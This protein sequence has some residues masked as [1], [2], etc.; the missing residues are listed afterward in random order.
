MGKADRVL[1]GGRVKGGKRGSVLGE[2]KGRIMGGERVKGG[3][4]GRV[5]GEEKGEGYRWEMGKG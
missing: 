3:I 2:E 4:R 1:D 5:L